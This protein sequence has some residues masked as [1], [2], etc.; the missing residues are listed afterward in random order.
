MCYRRSIV[1][2]AV[3]WK[4]DAY[5]VLLVGKFSFGGKL[6]RRIIR[7]Q[8]ND[9]GQTPRLHAQCCAHKH[10]RSGEYS[11]H[12]QSTFRHRKINVGIINQLLHFQCGSVI[13]SSSNGAATTLQI[14]NLRKEDLA[15][16]RDAKFSSGIHVS[17]PYLGCS[18]KN[19]QFQQTG[20]FPAG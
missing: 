17:C 19:S 15:P 2:D 18:L 11:I 10:E 8:S 20:R 1:V 3:N 5:K 12:P 9:H 13:K 4:L 14:C 16:S 7:R 6:R